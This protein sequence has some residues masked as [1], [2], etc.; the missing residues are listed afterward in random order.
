MKKA[1]SDFFA[2][3]LGIIVISGVCVIVGYC[4]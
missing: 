1:I 2:A 3:V 4:A